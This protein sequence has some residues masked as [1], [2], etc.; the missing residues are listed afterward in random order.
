MSSDGLAAQLIRL[1]VGETAARTYLQMLESAP[2]T[3]E[4]LVCREDD[5]ETVRLALK[6]LA[7]AG[8]A[9]PSGVDGAEFLPAN[10]SEALTAL[11][12]R[13]QAELHDA[14]LAV[15]TAYR[16]FRRAHSGMPNAQDLFEVVTGDAI[17]PRLRQ[18][19][20]T[21]R[22]QVRRLDSPPYFTGGRRNLL[23][24]EQLRRGIT[25]R[26]VY[27]GASFG[28]PGYLAENILPCLRAGEQ[29]RLL[30]EL[31]VKLTLFDDR[32]A[33][34]ALT[35]READ[36]NQSIVVV[37][38]CSLFSALEGLF[39]TSWAAALPLD[40]Q[41]RMA[42]QPI[43]P[44]ER[45]LLILLAAG[46]KDDEIAASLGVSRRTLFRYLETLMDR[47]GV[48]SRFQLGVFA[49]HNGWL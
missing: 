49:A 19:A 9:V 3:A 41:G 48:S 1:G 30:P 23:E 22:H 17:I 7:D 33:T 21:V 35:I 20:T 26:C 18:L 13:R 34:I 12:T 8:L 38:P 14:R 40:R 25:Y 24:E 36:R 15:Q 31:P 6:E 43:R 10:P 27:S 37:R 47:A 45:Q 11:T 4:G 5:A 32:A 29:A 28:N 46:L 2:V 39:E 42:E 16:V 44:I